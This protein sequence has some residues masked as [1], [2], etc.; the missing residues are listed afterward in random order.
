MDHHIEDALFSNYGS[1]VD[2]SGWGFD[3]VTTGYGDLQSGHR[4]EWY[5]EIFGGTSG[6]TPI[7]AGHN[8]LAI[9]MYTTEVAP[10]IGL[11]GNGLR[12]PGGSKHSNRPHFTTLMA[13]QVA[14]SS[15]YSFT[16][17][18][19]RGVTLSTRLSLTW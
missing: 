19:V 12:N 9:D 2:L 5:T 6:A 15:Q 14:N 1:R 13:L 17:M 11:F 10:G 8:I 3:V 4:D 7:V 16:A 18:L